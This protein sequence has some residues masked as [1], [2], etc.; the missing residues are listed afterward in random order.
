MNRAFFFSL[1][2]PLWVLLS[3]I[4][5]THLGYYLILPLL[6]IILTTERGLPVTQVGFILGTGSI[7]YLIGS[8][9]GGWLTDRIG[10]RRT[11]VSGLLIRGAGLLGY[12]FAGSV[13]LLFGTAVISG[14]GGGIYTPPAKSG[15]AVYAT[16]ENKSTA[17]SFRGIAANIGVTIGPLL[18][19][20]IIASSSTALFVAS[21]LI[22]IGLALAHQLLLPTDPA[23]ARD[24]PH[25]QFAFDILKDRPFLV[26]SLMTVFIWALYAQFTFSI[27][28]RA[29]DILPNP[30]SVGLLWSITSL[31]I[32]FL[33]API[34]RYVS[35]SWHP[36]ILLA[37][38]AI[39]MGIGLGS[40]MWSSR[41]YHLLI[42]VV[43]F[44]FGEM[45]IMPTVDTVVSEIAKPA[46]IG[47][48]FGIASFVWGMG[49]SLGN[50]G[51]GELISLGKN[52]GAPALP[53]LIF[54]LTGGVLGLIL[55]G[56]RMWA[57]LAV[58]L[59]GSLR[60][61]VDNTLSPT[62]PWRKKVK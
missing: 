30:K 48:Y 37:N 9:I 4:L 5:F 54:A 53:W 49:E 18:G 60:E 23:A 24:R 22:H 11:L 28:L 40:V 62:V 19:T 15:I 29:A 12:G 8:L 20:L 58:P 14:I 47:S 35:N 44:T 10:Q 41:F 38:G 39:L 2:R 55:Y 25:Q 33:Q 32:I 31:M 61:R 16:E 6:A 36:L 52:L 21:F 7:S 57:P 27:P 46:L 51:G 59:S 42:S 34:T 13:P 17:F 45:L 43:I 1:G 3:G 26:F 56:L 50:A